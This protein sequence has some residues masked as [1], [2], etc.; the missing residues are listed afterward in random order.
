MPSVSCCSTRLACSGRVSWSSKQ[1]FLREAG[2]DGPSPGGSKF[3]SGGVLP[4]RGG[5]INL[6]VTAFYACDSSVY[7]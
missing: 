4:P 1:V 6:C 5:W 3:V 2:V 7:M